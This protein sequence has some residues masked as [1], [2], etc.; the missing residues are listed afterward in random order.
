MRVAAALLAICSLAAQP[1]ADALLT[2]IRQKM[3]ENLSRLPDYTCR[4]TIERFMGAENAKRRHPIDTVHIEVGYV[5]GKE[6]Y[7]WPGQKF[8]SKGLDEMMPAGGVVA[9]GDF[10]LHVRSIFL[11]NAATFTYAGRSPHN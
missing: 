7:A 6:L 1:A 3:R 8:A 2:G 5:D 9:T 11:G 4:L 10:A